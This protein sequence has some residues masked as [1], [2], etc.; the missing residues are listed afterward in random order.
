MAGGKAAVEWIR[1]AAGES[2]GPG[3]ELLDRGGVIR[4][5]I[6]RNVLR[7]RVR[8]GT[9][10]PVGVYLDHERDIYD[11][12]CRHRGKVCRHVVAAL[13]YAS[14][15]LPEMIRYEGNGGPV[16][17]HLLEGLSG[18]EAEDLTVRGITDSNDAFERLLAVLGRKEILAR[19]ECVAEIGEM[20][21]ELYDYHGWTTAELDFDGFFRKAK[22]YESRENHRGAACIYQGVSEA[23]ADNMEL[24]DDSNGYYGDTFQKAIRGMARCISAEDSGHPRKR[25]YIS[26]LHEMFVRNDPDYFEEFYDEA[27]RAVCTTKAD[28]EYW[29]TLHEPLVPDRIPGHDDFVR[30]YRAATMVEMQ[31]HILRRL[32]DPS[33]ED[34]Y[35]KY[36]QTVPEICEAYVRALA[37]HDVD[38][39][40]QVA[41]EGRTRFPWKKMAVPRAGS[42]HCNRAIPSPDQTRPA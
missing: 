13:L 29:R 36:Y 17:D 42:A 26:Y 32:R 28:L 25:Q 39:A 18:K 35:K 2:F 30:H 5:R 7:A 24:V 11:C 16:A 23:I 31:E 22:G 21:R 37:R 12:I 8:D 38:R 41:K 3:Q 6:C 27:L 14:G 9:V 34:L 40:R 20:F 15:N 10:H 4:A 1:G 19:M 33:L